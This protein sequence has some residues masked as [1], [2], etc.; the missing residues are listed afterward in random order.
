MP[1]EALRGWKDLD[2]LAGNRIFD[3]L[4]M[5]EFFPLLRYGR[6]PLHI[7]AYSKVDFLSFPVFDECD[8]PKPVDDGI[9]R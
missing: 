8:A 1:A 4:F 9:R 3:L 5:L 6:D 7:P 2:G